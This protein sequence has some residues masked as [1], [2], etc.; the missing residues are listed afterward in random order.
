[1]AT[2]RAMYTGSEAIMNAFDTMNN[3]IYSVWQGKD[4]LFQN[5]DADMQKARNFLMDMIAAAEQS[6]NTDIL[7]I[8]FHPVKEG[9]F[10]TD[11]T[12]I[13]STLFVRI[14]ELP[15]AAVSGVNQNGNIPYPLWKTLEGLAGLPA[16]INTSLGAIEE[17]LTA[18]EQVEDEPGPTESM[19]G[20]ISGLMEN[21]VIMGLISKILPA[22]LPGVAMPQPSVPMQVSGV[23][24][25]MAEPNT[26]ASAEDL[27]QISQADYIKLDNALARLIP[28][29][30][31]A[32]DL[33]LLAD[34]AEQKPEIFKMMLSQLRTL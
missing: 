34:L 26:I 19:L 6:G 29:C 12:P 27:P 24:E 1:M 30:N 17:R 13:V 33:S 9:K 8:K 16:Q 22:I 2:S 3:P 18:L 21:P 4:I 31:V 5:N 23:N 14:V 25:S 28:H 32:E 15:S 11:K 10:I 7:A 20:R